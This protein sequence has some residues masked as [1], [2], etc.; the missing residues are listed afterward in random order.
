MCG[1]IAD[2]VSDNSPKGLD[3]SQFLDTKCAATT[4]AAQFAVEVT[5]DAISG[6]WSHLSAFTAWTTRP[7][8]Q[9]SAALHNADGELDKSFSDIEAIVMTAAEGGTGDSG[10]ID[11]LLVNTVAKC[12]LD[13]DVKFGSGEADI[14][15]GFVLQPGEREGQKGGREVKVERMTEGERVRE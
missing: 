5:A 2:L 3:D 9:Y 12:P 1:N 11:S 4:F 15:K 13:G 7:G 14:T 8:D 10:L 6:N